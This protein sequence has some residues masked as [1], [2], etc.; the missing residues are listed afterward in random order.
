MFI[1]VCIPRIHLSANSLSCTELSA[2]TPKR[3]NGTSLK[4]VTYDELNVY[5]KG[6]EKPRNQGIMLL[7]GVET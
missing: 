3:Q 4:K 1:I 2:E 5:V 6:K 7:L